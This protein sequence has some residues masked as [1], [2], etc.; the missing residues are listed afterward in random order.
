MSSS[1]WWDSVEVY[2]D[3]GYT[4]A[5]YDPDDSVRTNHALVSSDIHLLLEVDT[6]KLPQIP[7]LSFVAEGINAWQNDIRARW[8][9]G[10]SFA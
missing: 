2:D 4:P 10:V 6:W 7:A 5:D 3:N 8:I 1:E 9:R